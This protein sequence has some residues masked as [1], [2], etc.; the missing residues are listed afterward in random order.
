MKTT[1][2]KH[3]E[4]RSTWGHGGRWVGEEGMAE[5][6]RKHCGEGWSPFAGGD[7][8][9]GGQVNTHQDVPRVTIPCVWFTT[10]TWTIPDKAVPQHGGHIK[11]HTSQERES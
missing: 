1:A 9:D 2:R 10:L 11:M 5:G 4:D 7:G 6:H 3:K 8:G